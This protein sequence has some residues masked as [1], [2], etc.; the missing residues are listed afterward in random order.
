VSDTATAPV[1]P[2]FYATVVV[3][4]FSVWLFCVMYALVR[5]GRAPR[6]RDW[7]WIAVGLAALGAIQT[8]VATISA[9]LWLPGTGVAVAVLYLVIWK[10]AAPSVTAAAYIVVK[11]CFLAAFVASLEWQLHFY[12]SASQAWPQPTWLRLALLASA[13]GAV[14]GAAL[15]LE[16]RHHAARLD[17]SLRE[18][19]TMLVIGVVTFVLCNLSYWFPST[20]FSSSTGTEVFNIR[21]LVAG[22]GVAAMYAYQNQ[23]LERRAQAELSSIRVVLRTQHAQYQRSRESIDAVNHRYHDLKYQIAVLRGEVDTER[24]QAHLDEIEQS[25]RDYETEFK[26]GNGV[27]DTMLTAAASTC[28]RHGI[29][30]TCVA[31]GAL[32]DRI[33]EMDVA[34]IFGNALDNAVESARK[35]ND[36]AKRLIHVSVTQFN[37]FVVIRVENYVEG[38]RALQ[39]SDGLPVTTKADRSSHGLGLR[40]VRH[41]ASRHNGNVTAHVRDN[42]FELTVMLSP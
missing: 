30:L 39:F 37:D 38:S 4:Q 41:V 27:L 20:P 21:T 31:D 28:A 35:V 36:Q 15:A 5:L 17:P 29:Q 7:A 6:P 19:Q 8:A 16:L 11:A 23:L 10:C 18:L 14:L 33:S 42:W 24:R 1:V 25:I 3:W 12:L 34:T 13:Y 26:T 2:L 40:S 32:L 22:F 9:S